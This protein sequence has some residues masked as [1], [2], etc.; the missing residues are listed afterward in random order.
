MPCTHHACHTGERPCEDARRVR[1][2]HGPAHGQARL[3]RPG[4]AR[5]VEWHKRGGARADGDGVRRRDLPRAPPQHI[6]WHTPTRTHSHT[7]RTPPPAF[8]TLARA[9]DLSLCAES[10]IES[11]R[12]PACVPCV[13]VATQVKLCELRLAKSQGLLSAAR[14]VVSS[15]GVAVDPLSGVADTT[16]DEGT[17]QGT[18][19]WVEAS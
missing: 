11:H 12:P 7:S 16:G 17:D 14:Q 18:D 9:L 15:G 6:V 19:A 1:F 3:S 10:H 13:G 4:L 8:F 5:M 2:R